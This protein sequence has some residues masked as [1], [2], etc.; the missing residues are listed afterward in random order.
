MAAVAADDDQV[1]LLFFGEAMDFLARLTIS[2]V[3]MFGAKSGILVGK[4]I[5]TLACLVELLLLQHRQIHRHV[6]AKG[7]GHGLDDMHHG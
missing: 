6:A 3:A 5:Q 1:A 2:Q 7:H 4:F